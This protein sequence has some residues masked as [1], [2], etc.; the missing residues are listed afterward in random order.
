MSDF[1]K[2]FMSILSTGV[3]K[4]IVNSDALTIAQLNAA[5]TLLIQ[6]AI[7]FD[8]QFTPGT[9]RI[10]A[11]ATLTVYINPSTTI[12]FTINFGESGSIFTGTD[13][14]INL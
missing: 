8:V 2:D 5:I 1:D 6:A 7:P 4:N 10:A 9:R 12:N 11:A 14:D 13:T 3:F